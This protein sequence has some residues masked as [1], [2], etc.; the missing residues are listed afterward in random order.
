L[1]K[2][3]KEVC[4]PKLFLDSVYEN[5]YIPNSAS[6]FIYHGTKDAPVNHEG[7]AI[8]ES[9][10]FQHVE[11]LQ[12][13]VLPT[14]NKKLKSYQAVDVDLYQGSVSPFFVIKHKRGGALNLE[15]LKQEIEHAINVINSPQIKPCLFN[16]M[17]LVNEK[18][19]TS[20]R[21]SARLN[22]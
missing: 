16:D 11:Y 22:K 8:I 5:Q 19:T 15:K 14:L 13:I 21:R 10:P 2:L 9:D 7:Q 4:M 1:E 6:A 20:L 17:R 12:N 3:K 18:K